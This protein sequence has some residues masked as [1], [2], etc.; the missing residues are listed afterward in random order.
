MTE[1]QGEQVFAIKEALWVEVHDM[2]D[3]KLSG[4]DLKVAEA[5]R[6]Q[7]TEQF[8]FWKRGQ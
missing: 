5:V 6:E 8:R 7:L 2:V 1:D 4:V 3:A